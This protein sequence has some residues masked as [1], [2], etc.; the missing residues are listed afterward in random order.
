M[1]FPE[2]GGLNRM[3]NY[4]LARGYLHSEKLRWSYGA[5][6]GEAGDAWQ[7]VITSLSVGDMVQAL[8]GAGFAGIYLDRFGYADNGAQIERE[9]SRVLS[10]GP[11]VASARLVFFNLEHY[12]LVLR[13]G[14]SSA[15]WQERLD[16]LNPPFIVYE[17]GFYPEETSPGRIWRWSRAESSLRIFN[18]SSRPKSLVL[19]M[20]IASGSDEPG[21][22][23]NNS[24]PS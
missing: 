22:I 15:E 16:R 3:N 20:T 24:A 11:L 10:E 5:M 6:K 1:Q 7:Q 18:L 4:D 19:E 23:E 14:M 13:S 8:I 2:G 12:K 9:L 17:N 21:S